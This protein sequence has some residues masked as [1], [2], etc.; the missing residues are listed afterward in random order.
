MYL[1]QEYDERDSALLHFLEWYMISIY[2]IAR[3]VNFDNL[4]TLVVDCFVS[5]LK[6]LCFI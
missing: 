1:W 2:H 6:L 3:N 4:V 5:A